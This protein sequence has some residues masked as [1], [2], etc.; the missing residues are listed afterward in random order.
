MKIL[1]GINRKKTTEL[2]DKTIHVYGVTNV[3]MFILAKITRNLAFGKQF[4]GN[5]D[6]SYS[7]NYSKTHTGKSNSTGEQKLGGG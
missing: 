2:F 1:D 6:Y 3:E 4:I 5:E 7:V